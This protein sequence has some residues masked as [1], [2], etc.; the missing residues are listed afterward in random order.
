MNTCTKRTRVL[1]R[2]QSKSGCFT[3]K[4]R[5]VKCDEAK[6]TCQ[7]GTKSG[8][9]CEGY[10]G[11]PYEPLGAQSYEPA[12]GIPVPED[13][14]AAAEDALHDAD[15]QTRLVKM[16]CP[17]DQIHIGNNVL[18]RAILAGTA[19]WPSAYIAL[20]ALETLTEVAKSGR[21]DTD[22]TVRVNIAY[23]YGQSMHSLSKELTTYPSS[24]NGLL[25]TCLLLAAIELLQRNRQ[26]ALKHAVGGLTPS[27][28]F[29]APCTSNESDIESI[30]RVFDLQILLYSKGV[31]L[32]TVG[33]ADVHQLAHIT[34][35][36]VE[37]ALLERQGVMVL[38]SAH[39]LIA[40]IHYQ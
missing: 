24:S 21:H 12:Q 9:V 15:L 16:L 39:S 18:R 25:V 20:N 29:P 6:P 40:E 17:Y 10:S 2:A 11:S 13:R 38:H 30:L 28:H 32:P 27:F 37:P 1:A 3:C 35:E 22:T 19:L 4:Y 34:G 31:R 8:V 23:S 36:R 33:P 26:S 7:R 5:K 14:V